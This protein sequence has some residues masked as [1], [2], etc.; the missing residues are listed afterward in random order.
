MHNPPLVGRVGVGWLIKHLGGGGL[1]KINWTA[2]GRGGCIPVSMPVKSSTTLSACPYPHGQPPAPGSPR[3]LPTRPPESQTQTPISSPA[4]RACELR[5]QQGR[6][7]L[8]LRPAPATQVTD[9][10]TPPAPTPT[11][12]VRSLPGSTCAAERPPPGSACVL[13]RAR[14]RA[15]DPNS[16]PRRRSEPR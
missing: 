4:A 5:P 7:A 9:A 8:A 11:S 1:A 2:V 6:P 3:R 13:A 15:R 16:S 14:P 12:A 10:A